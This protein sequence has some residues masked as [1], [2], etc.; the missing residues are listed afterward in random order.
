M[1]ESKKIR[2]KIK[3]KKIKRK[4]I[5]FRKVDRIKNIKLLK[6]LLR[7]DGK[8]RDKRSVQK[9]EELNVVASEIENL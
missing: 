4:R 8:E 7:L 5:K 2:R 1:K 9:D 6:F 3:E